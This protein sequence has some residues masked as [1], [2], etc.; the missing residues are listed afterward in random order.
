MKGGERESV[1]E[2]GDRELG[3]RVEREGCTVARASLL[4][5]SALV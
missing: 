3:F 1:V 4:R 2:G 5:A